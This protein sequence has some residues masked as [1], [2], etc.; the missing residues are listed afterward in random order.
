MAVIANAY[1]IDTRDRITLETQLDLIAAAAP[2]VWRVS[3][4]HDLARAAD[5]AAAIA[6]HAR[7]LG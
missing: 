5:V 4:P 3:Y 1:R 2:P 6:A 7:T